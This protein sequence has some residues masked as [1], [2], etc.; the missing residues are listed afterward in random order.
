MVGAPAQAGV[1]PKDQTHVQA[2]VHTHQRGAKEEARLTYRNTHRK[3]TEVWLESTMQVTRKVNGE[4][5]GVVAISR[6]ITEQKNLENRLETLA[7][8]DGLTGLATRRRFDERLDEE[9]G[10]AYRNR[11]SIA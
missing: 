7:I 4:I 10:R 9:W 6:D 5:D 3:K 1:K 8:A 2:L 11:S